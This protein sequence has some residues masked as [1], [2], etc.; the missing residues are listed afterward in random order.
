MQAT[1]ALRGRA[2]TLMHYDRAPL[3]EVFKQYSLDALLENEVLVD[4]LEREPLV[5][6]VVVLGFRSETFRVEL[7]GGSANEL[8]NAVSQVLEQISGWLSHVA[9]LAPLLNEMLY[10]REAT[11]TLDYDYRKFSTVVH[12]QASHLLKQYP[13]LMIPG[14]HSAGGSFAVG[15]LADK[16]VQLTGKPST[17]FERE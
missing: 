6:E 2:V 7:R 16:W 13:A 15:L 10:I 12:E 11:G 14:M 8:N 4:F 1:Q 3:V 5:E 17:V 9:G